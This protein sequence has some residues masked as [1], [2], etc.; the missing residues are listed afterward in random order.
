MYKRQAWAQPSLDEVKKEKAEEANRQASLFGATIGEARTP[1]QRRHDAGKC[2]PCPYYFSP[3]GC[4]RGAECSYCHLEHEAGQ[5]HKYHDMDPEQETLQEQLAQAR[6]NS[7]PPWERRDHD[8]WTTGVVD[9]PV[10]L[11]SVEKQL[12]ISR[13]ESPAPTPEGSPWKTWKPSLPARP[14]GPSGDTYPIFEWDEDDEDEKGKE[15]A[16]AYQHQATRLG[17][18]EEGLLADTGA[19]DNVTGMDFVK[20]QTEAASKLGLKTRWEKLDKPKRLAGVGGRTSICTHQA[21]IPGVL[22]DGTMAT[23][24]APVIPPDVPEQTSVPP[25]YGLKSMAAENVYMGTRSGVMALVPDGKEE[26]IKWPAGTKFRQCKKAPSGHWMLTF[27]HWENKAKDN[28]IAHVFTAA[29]TQE[30]RDKPVAE[31]RHHDDSQ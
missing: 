15:S 13:G 24:A 20:R 14:T 27:S 25:L 23:Y 26:E 18:C 7:K 8:P 10:K 11:S 1:M 31:A 28:K 12:G 6:E 17:D 4:Y 21:V 29:E 2:K 3:K 5:R 19:V 16:L 30:P 9:K 22:A